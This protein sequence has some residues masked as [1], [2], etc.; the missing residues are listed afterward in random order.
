MKIKK[1][2]KNLGLTNT[3]SEIY[4]AGLPFYGIG[5]YELEKKTNI[6]RTT[7]YHAINTLVQKG[8][9]S[10]KNIDGKMVF[11]MTDPEKFKK[12]INTEISVLSAQRD[13][14]EKMIP[15][16]KTQRNK[17]K[18]DIISHYEG[19]NGIKTVVDEALYC[20][21]RSWEV[22]APLKN[23]FSEFSDDYAKYYIET[24]KNKNIKARSLWEFDINR[25]VLT[26]AEI[27]QRQPRILPKVMHGMFKSVIIIFD[28]KVAIINSVEKLSA[29]LIESQEIHDTFFAIFKGLWI[30]S[31]PYKKKLNKLVKSK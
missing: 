29:I 1:I 12:V 8:L 3:E 16:L 28:N 11:T 6:K 21:S 20:K 25:R 5:V 18:Q 19:I 17:L 23:F 10:K 26:D 31:N 13:E 14:I 27:S 9:V 22:I 2:L 15:L 24:R 4:L 7:I 30:I